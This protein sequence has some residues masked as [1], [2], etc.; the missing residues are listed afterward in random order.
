MITAVV[1][2]STEAALIPEAA[3]AIA[4]IDGI[5]EVY[6]VTG[7]VDLIAVAKVR[8]HEDLATVIADR[9]SKVNG[10]VHTQTY[11]A[12]QTYSSQALDQAFSL[13]LDD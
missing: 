7:E 10:V 11:I 13:G 6:S 5:A 9:V 1:M 2:I 12:F 4:E 3:K 8:R